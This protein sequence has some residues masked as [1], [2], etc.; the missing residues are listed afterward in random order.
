M[1]GPRPTIGGGGDAGRDLLVLLDRIVGEALPGEAVEAYGV[2]ETETTVRAYDGEVES[3]S[4]AR[5][6]G[7][8]VRVIAGGRVGY[9][10]TADLSDAAL[11][12]ALESARSNATV[13]SADDA[14]VL[15]AGGALED[16]P[17]LYDA[18]FEEV[19]TSRKVELALGLEAAARGAGGPVK[20]VDSARYGDGVGTVAI[21]STT[22]VRGTYRRCDAYV[23]VEVLAEAD[24][25]TTSAYGVDLARL[26]DDV[27][28]E[29][30]ARE[31]AE[32]AV[33]LLGGRKPPSGRIPILLDPFATASLL[34]VLAGALSAEAIQKG[35]SLF[36]G[37]RG[38]VIGSERVTL[39]DD[40][41]LPD[42]PATRPWDAEGT[43]TR[44]TTLVSAG[45]LAGFLHNIYTAAKDGTASTGN[46]SRGGF[47]SP[48]GV[49]PTNLF[50]APGARSQAE[51]FARAGTAFY[52][53]QV[54]GVHSGANAISGDVSVGASGLLV[55][56]GAFA[57]PIREA[58]IAGTIPGMLAG[59]VEVGSDLR[60]FPFGAGMGGATLLLDGMTL[61]GA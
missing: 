5:T 26:P 14:N 58:T 2:D 11:A 37:K 36:A 43:P 21:A 31:A 30:A 20:G 3:L 59:L 27:D 51:L 6:R 39:V 19:P 32:R 17:G 52:C 4:N 25:S 18:A 15:P 50:L 53:Q 1:S 46:A 49:A 38:E 33:R 56:D 12:D 41:R 61:A 13:A 57:E 60:F 48:P 55:R 35:R 28:V 16:L 42:G 9:A 22:G 29:G 34:G 44:R 47:K 10:Y 8:G 45:V 54:L 40:G 24:G 23:A 7:I